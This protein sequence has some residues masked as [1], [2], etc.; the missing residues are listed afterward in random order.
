QHAPY[1]RNS[2]WK[3][4]RKI[5]RPHVIRYECY[6][7]AYYRCTHYAASHVTA[8]D[9]IFHMLDGKGPVKEYK[10]SLV[11][12]IEASED[13]TGETEYFR[14]RC[15]K[16]GNLHL[17]FKRADLLALFNRIAGKARL[18]FAA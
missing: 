17:E 12:A 7:T 3:L 13:G 15:C 10:G 5:I 9:N 18:G 14:F 8:L 16:N 6:R 4:N 11:S 1:R 2:E